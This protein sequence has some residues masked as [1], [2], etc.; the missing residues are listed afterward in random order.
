MERSSNDEQNELGELEEFAWMDDALSALPDELLASAL[1]SNGYPDQVF[2]NF[3]E[4]WDHSY[5]AKEPAVGAAQPPPE[6]KPI[7]IAVESDF[8]H[9]RK[10]RAN[11]I[12]VP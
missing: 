10:I 9:G 12:F 8:V 5:F 6:Q 1:P 4:A 2:S 11:P 7:I 3:M